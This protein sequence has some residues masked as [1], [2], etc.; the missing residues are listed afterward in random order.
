[1]EQARRNVAR[2]FAMT[3]SQLGQCSGPLQLRNVVK[4]CGV[5]VAVIVTAYAWTRD[6]WGDRQGLAFTRGYKRSMS[7]SRSLQTARTAH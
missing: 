2:A 6:G 5:L 4:R 1:M 7:T 3:R